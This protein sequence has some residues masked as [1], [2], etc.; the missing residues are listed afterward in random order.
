MNRN[1]LVWFWFILIVGV[2]LSSQG[3]FEF[4]LFGSIALIISKQIEILNK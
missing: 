3:Y 4:A 2:I 1:P